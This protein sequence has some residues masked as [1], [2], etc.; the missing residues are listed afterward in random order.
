MSKLA[1]FCCFVVMTVLMLNAFVGAGEKTLVK[2]LDS[3]CTV[4]HSLERVRKAVGQKDLE[5]WESYIGRMQAKGAK[6]DDQEKKELSN[7]LATL[8]TPEF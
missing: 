8:K 2:M 5:G 1:A 7:W 4:C 6:I 3:Y